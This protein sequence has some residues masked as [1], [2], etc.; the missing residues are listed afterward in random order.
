MAVLRP[1]HR[2]TS[3]TIWGDWFSFSSLRLLWVLQCGGCVCQKEW[4]RQLW[5]LDSGTWNWRL[6]SFQTRCYSH[7]LENSHTSRWITDRDALDMGEWNLYFLLKNL[8]SAGLA[9]WFGFSSVSIHS[10]NKSQR[11][12]QKLP[13]A[14]WLAQ[15][16]EFP[17]WIKKASTES[18][19]PGPRDERV[20]AALCFVSGELSAPL[21]LSSEFMLLNNPPLPLNWWIRA[22]VHP[23]MMQIGELSTIHDLKFKLVSAGVMLFSAIHTPFPAI[24]PLE[25]DEDPCMSPW[26]GDFFASLAPLD[27]EN[28]FSKLAHLFML[29]WIKLEMGLL[30]N[31][32]WWSWR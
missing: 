25:F 9:F 5:L 18:T 19:P 29:W 4:R 2:G 20:S 1:Y 14:R 30:I 31:W 27:D 11:E 22:L 12:D 7:N 16:G 23:W 13:F 21:M 3:K 28:P 32:Q 8:N 15:I 24:H 10:P 6:K 26:I 17:H